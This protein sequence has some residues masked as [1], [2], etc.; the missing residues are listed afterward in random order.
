MPSANYNTHPSR[1]TRRISE[2]TLAARVKSFLTQPRLILNSLLLFIFSAAWIRDV[3]YWLPRDAF[4]KSLNY[5]AYT[6]W[7]IDYSQGFIRRG[8]SGEIWRLVPTAVA[9]L[10]FVAV[11]SWILI[12]SVAFGYVRLLARSWKILPPL[13]LFGLLFLPSLFFFYI[14]DHNAIARKEI[15]GYVTVLLHLLIVEKSFPLGDGTPH[16]DGNL[17]RYV[18]WLLPVAVILLPAIILIHEGSFLLFVPLH[19]MVTLTILRMNPPR[20][21]KRAALW[22]GLLYLP[23]MIA[24]GAVYL[25]GPPSHETLL[26]V[27]EKWNAAGAIREGSCHLPPSRL[28]GSTLPASF[29]PMEWPLARAASLTGFF[30]S[31]HWKQWILILPTLGV[32]LWYLVRQT[33]YSI[34]RSRS[35]QSFSPQSAL[36]YSGLF[37]WK[38]FL[39]PLLLALPIYFTAWDYGR[40]FTVAS[41]NF[42]MLAVSV[43]LPCRE[44][45]LQKKSADEVSAATDSREHL[46]HRL[47]FYGVSIIICI[48]ALVLWLPHYCLF[49]CEMIRSPLQF[50][51]HT[52]IAR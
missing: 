6:D 24:F 12:L 13:T 47:I 16:P 42:S 44:F 35:P 22:T 32:L 15:L 36:R 8:L 34:L 38:Y 52:F 25:A 37:F 40:W 9:P 21:F 23:A 27:C 19:G 31:T 51:S 50:F 10:E 20:D 17:R 48:L 3:L 2:M 4:E 29:E 14:H 30:I 5:W 18:Q 33:V 45:A 7:L 26:G 1:S 28:S 46:D 49:S 43:N 11:F 39:V 41:I